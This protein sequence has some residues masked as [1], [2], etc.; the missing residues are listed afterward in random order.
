MTFE[1]SELLCSRS[2]PYELNNRW[3]EIIDPASTL[4]FTSKCSLIDV[5]EL[6]HHASPHPDLGVT[7]NQVV[8]DHADIFISFAYATDFIE[9]VECVEN[10]VE[11]TG[12]DPDKTLF[13]FDLFVNDQWYVR[14]VL[15]L[16]LFVCTHS[17]CFLRSSSS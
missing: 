5:L 9:L 2:L 11:E 12:S 16:L 6:Y 8:G 1:S 15:L 13:W 3:N 4:T 10:Y 14:V 7:Y 17:C